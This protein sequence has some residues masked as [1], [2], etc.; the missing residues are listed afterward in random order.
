MAATIKATEQVIEV[1][2][3]GAT[4]TVDVLAESRFDGVQGLPIKSVKFVP[5]A[6]NDRL[7]IKDV[8]GGEALADSPT[9]CELLALDLAPVGDG[10][11]TGEIVSPSIDGTNSTLSANHKVIITY[12]TKTIKKP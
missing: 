9:C 12:D 6:A 4:E 8:S 3:I 7:I 5:G 10:L 2:G 11:F 1:S